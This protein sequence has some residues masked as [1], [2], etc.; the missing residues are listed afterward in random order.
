[1][2]VVHKQVQIRESIVNV[3]R[4]ETGA[5]KQYGTNRIAVQIAGCVRQSLEPG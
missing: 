4:T 5:V 1:M 2:I 3:T